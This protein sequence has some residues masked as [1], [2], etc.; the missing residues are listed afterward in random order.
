[1]NMLRALCALVVVTAACA[2][3]PGSAAALEP[4]S[5]SCNGGGCGGW[6][7]SNVTVSWSFDSS[8]RHGVEWLRRVRP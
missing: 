2:A 1:M 8:R 6:F 3:L 4:P 5:A 7:R